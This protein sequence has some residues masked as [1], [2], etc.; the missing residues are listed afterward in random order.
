MYYVT[1]ET[2]MMSSVIA[3]CPDPVPLQYFGQVYAN[4]YEVFITDIFLSKKKANMYLATFST[5]QQ[6][7]M[8]LVII[9][10]YCTLLT[11]TRVL[12]RFDF[13]DASVGRRRR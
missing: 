11:V 8:R 2:P 10:K 4:V 6:S 13:A 1:P 3:D 12:R 9:K 5:K 7:K